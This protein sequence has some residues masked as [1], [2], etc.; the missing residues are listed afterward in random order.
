M[1][2]YFRRIGR[3]TVDDIDEALR[4]QKEMR[5]Q[6]KNMQF[7]DILV[8]MGLLTK[9]ETN[10]IIYIKDE[11]KKRF[12]F[13]ANMLGKSTTTDTSHEQI[14]VNGEGA[15]KSANLVL[16]RQEIFELRN[17]LSQIASIVKK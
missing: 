2:D 9:E 14:R 13:N 1:G 3:I 5:A 16:L 11:C 12:I 17:K 8:L 7:A 10:A 4:R 6:G 15:D